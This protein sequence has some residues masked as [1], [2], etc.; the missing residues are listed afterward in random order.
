MPAPDFLIE[1]LPPGPAVGTGRP[2]GPATREGAG[3]PHRARLPTRDRRETPEPAMRPGQPALD[4]LPQVQQ[5]MPPIRDLDRP[6][7]PERDTAGVLA[8][9]V[10]GDGADPAVAPKPVGQR[11]GAPVRQQVDNAMPLQV[12]EN[13]PVGRALAQGP[14]VDTQDA[15]GWPPRQGQAAHQ[16]QHRVTARWHAEVPQHPPGRLAAQGDADPTLRRGQAMRTMRMRRNQPRQPLDKGLPQTG[17]ITAV[18]ASHRQLETNLAPEAGQIGRPPQSAA[19]DRL[20]R[21]ATVWAARAALSR[22]G[23]DLDATGI[24]AGH[25][26]DPAPRQEMQVVHPG[27]YSSPARLTATRT[28]ITHVPR[29]GPARPGGGCARSHGSIPVALGSGM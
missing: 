25:L 19:V 22:L 7:R 24:R 17:G 12:D 28:V 1:S 18:Q 6:R 2:L 15:R 16:A 21:L 11:W 9:A 10:A 29:A 20:A 27:L 14:V 8:R 5:Q 3:A 26:S 4:H 23:M 13:R